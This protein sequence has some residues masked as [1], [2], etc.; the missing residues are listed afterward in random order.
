MRRI[1]DD[2]VQDLDLARRIVDRRFG[3]EQQNLR[4][5]QVGGDRGADI[6]R[7]EEAV[8]GGVG[9]DGEGQM[10]VGRV[11]VLGARGFLGGVFEGVAADRL[12]DAAGLRVRRR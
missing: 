5:D 10:P 12:V 7:I 6:D 3:A 11:E 1:L 2:L 4:A 9:D 8:A